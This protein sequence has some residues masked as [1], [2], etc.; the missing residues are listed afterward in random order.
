MR[1]S[2][3]IVG[4]FLLG[5]LALT[6]VP[7]QAVPSF[8][9]YVAA[10]YSTWQI[11]G[12][13]SGHYIEIQGGDAARWWQVWRISNVGSFPLTKAIMVIHFYRVYISGGWVYD[14]EIIEQCAH[15][16]NSNGIWDDKYVLRLG[17]IEVGEYSEHVVNVWLDASVVIASMWID[18]YYLP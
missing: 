3:G 6:I 14:P 1:K 9:G 11:S 18:V 17:T 5:T 16:I 13:E 10:D 12:A 4:V 15:I 8:S 2:L 7:V